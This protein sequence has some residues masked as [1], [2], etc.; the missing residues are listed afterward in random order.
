ML[1]HK[2]VHEGKP[3]PCSFEGCGVIRRTQYSINCHFNETHGKVKRRISLEDQLA[4]QERRVQCPKCDFMIKAGKC[5]EYNLKHHMEIHKKEKSYKCPVEE[6]FKKIAY[7]QTSAEHGYN[8][9][10]QYFEH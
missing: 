2:I 3:H 1:R 7:L 10:R 9:P 4:K 5:P 6:C 8:L